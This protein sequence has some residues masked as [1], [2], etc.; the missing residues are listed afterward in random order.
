MLTRTEIKNWMD[1]QIEA[2]NI[3]SMRLVVEKHEDGVDDTIG[4]LSSQNYIHIGGESV[5]YIADRLGLDLCVTGRK[6]DPENPYEV[7]ILYKGIKFIGIETEAEYQ[8][9]G[10]VV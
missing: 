10:A 1:K 3:Q 4:N 5:R 6:R 2:M 7:F 9:K 8:E